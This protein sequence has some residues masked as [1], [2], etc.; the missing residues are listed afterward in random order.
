ML[1][2]TRAL[3]QVINQISLL[4]E[5]G[6]TLAAL[7][8]TFIIVYGLLP[9]GTDADITSSLY[10]DVWAATYLGLTWFL[11]LRS[12]PEQTRRWA[13]DQ[14]TAPRRSGLSLLRS[15]LLRALQVLFLVGRTS[16]LLFI[17]VI[18]L[19]GLTAALSLLPDVRDLQTAHGVL[20]AIL[21]VLGVLAAW[22][23]LHTCYG[24]Y[25][26]SRYYQ[27]DESPGGLKFPG[28][29]EPRQ[30]DFA[31]FAFTI[32]TSFAV[33]DVEV[34]ESTMRRGVLAH[35]ILSFFYN[36]TILALTINF[37]VG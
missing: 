20:A 9:S 24:L 23:V 26:A 18:S 35:Q 2:A 11:V 16:S 8:I 3:T 31:Y 34:T 10:W 12:S 7:L 33:S 22:G 36:T 21:N 13:L 14:R 28:E 17:I 25:Y 32:G 4:N 6:R 5:F 37:V 29:R 19:F 15:G 1:K 27:S 30:L